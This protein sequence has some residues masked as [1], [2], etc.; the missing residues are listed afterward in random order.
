MDCPLHSSGPLIKFVAKATWMRSTVSSTSFP[1]TLRHSSSE[2]ISISLPS[3]I[4]YQKIRVLDRIYANV[5]AMEL[6][7]GGLLLFALLSYAL[8]RPSQLPMTPNDSFDVPGN[9]PLIYCEDP[10]DYTF[11]IDHIDVVPNPPKA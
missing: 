8:Q 1:A 2:S 11:E 10:K 6:V 5:V 4:S 3:V 9:N 7:A